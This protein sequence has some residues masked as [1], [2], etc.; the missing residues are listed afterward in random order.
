MSL[1]RAPEAKDNL[2]VSSSSSSPTD[3]FSS[4]QQPTTR[5]KSAWN[6]CG[7]SLSY[8]LWS[9]YKQRDEPPP[10]PPI[11]YVRL[12]LFSRLRSDHPKTCVALLSAIEARFS[13]EM[14]HSPCNTILCTC[15]G[16]VNPR[17]SIHSSCH[18][19]P[20]LQTSAFHSTSNI[21]PFAVHCHLT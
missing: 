15:P 10:P 6:S 8:L 4:H 7:Q 13:R 3:A 12:S 17:P 19:I 9:N 16:K 1:M 18:V 11:S 5:G 21:W 2:C 20:V 14:V